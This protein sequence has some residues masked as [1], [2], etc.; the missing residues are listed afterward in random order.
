MYLLFLINQI[1]YVSFILLVLLIFKTIL[2]QHVYLSN[3]PSFVPT[4]VPS[5]GTYFHVPTFI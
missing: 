1:G 4:F 2:Y 5:L 3:V